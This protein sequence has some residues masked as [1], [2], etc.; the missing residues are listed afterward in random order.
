MKQWE[1]VEE[2]LEFAI[3]NEEAAASFYRRLAEMVEE[4]G[5]KSTFR[6]YAREEEQHKKLL[7]RFSELDD[8]EPSPGKVADLKIADYLVDVGEEEKLGYPESLVMAMKKEAAAAR[9]YGDMAAVVDDPK[10]KK[11]LLVLAEEEAKHK[12][13]FETEY[14]EN[15]LR[16]N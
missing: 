10:L 8:L 9:L 14:D 13:R 15:I 5:L 4:P 16:D 3:R 7:L 1:T 2:I 6:D 11:A 12:L